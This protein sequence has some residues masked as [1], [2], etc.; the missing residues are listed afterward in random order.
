MKIQEEKNPKI[1]YQ[2]VVNHIWDTFV[3]TEK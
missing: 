2:K 1:D 3:N